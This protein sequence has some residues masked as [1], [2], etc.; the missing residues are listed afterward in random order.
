MI[1]DQ[2]ER[3]LRSFMHRKPYRPF[4]V[5]LTDGRTIF[6]DEPAIAFG[7]GR[8]AYI[9]P[10]SSVDVF[11]CEQVQEFRLAQEEPAA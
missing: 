7:G 1:V 8:A 11:D 10:D 2:F 5:V 3:E 6:V 9:G 4:V